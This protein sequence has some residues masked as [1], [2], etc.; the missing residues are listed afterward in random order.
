MNHVEGFIRADRQMD[1]FEYALTHVLERHLAPTFQRTRP[2]T[3]EFYALAPVRKECAVVLSAVAHAGN[4]E[5]QAAKQAFAQGARELNGL[6]LE[7]RPISEAGL[8]GVRDSLTKL[9]RLAPRLKKDLMRAFVAAGA[10]DGSIT[11]G[12]GEILRVLADSLGLPMPP[13]LPGQ[14]IGASS[15]SR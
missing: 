5:P 11:V 4:K 8:V 12:E 6:A 1:L 10:A 15:K 3:V 2:P 9:E 7:L 13:I 14:R